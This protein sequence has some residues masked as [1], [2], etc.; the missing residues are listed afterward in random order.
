MFCSECGAAI[1]AHSKFCAKCGAKVEDEVGTE[2]TNKP[3]VKTHEAK[4]RPSLIVIIGGTFLG[5]CVLVAAVGLFNGG[6]SHT[7]TN[8]SVSAP[9]ESKQPPS[10]SPVAGNQSKP[11]YGKAIINTDASASQS[12]T[13]EKINLATI[14]ANNMNWGAEEI[15]LCETNLLM[16]SAFFLGGSV[17]DSISEDQRRDARMNFDTVDFVL[18]ILRFIKDTKINSGRVSQEQISTLMNVYSAQ[19]A[20]VPQ[21]D[22]QKVAINEKCLNAL[23]P[24]GK[25]L[26]D[27]NLLKTP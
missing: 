18:K 16:T 15:A 24:V 20:N 23:A 8:P 12:N 17:N 13:N 6:G 19:I 27:A 10:P 25:L 5:F 2:P 14:T 21:N 11:T 3:E 22:P 26:V 9:I 1:E 7:A 4:K